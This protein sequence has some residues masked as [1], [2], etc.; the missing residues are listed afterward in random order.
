M[1]PRKKDRKNCTLSTFRQT[2]FIQPCQC[3]HH[4]KD[5]S[6]CR[7]SKK[8]KKWTYSCNRFLMHGIERLLFLFSYFWVVILAHRWAKPWFPFKPLLTLIRINWNNEFIHLSYRTIHRVLKSR[9]LVGVAL[10]QSVMVIS[11][12]IHIDI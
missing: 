8:Y 7:G 3:V 2:G 5:S 10:W 11:T 6:V 9:F 1:L 12:S 4:I